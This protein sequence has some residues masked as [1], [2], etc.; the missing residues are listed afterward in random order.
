M[1]YFSSQVYIEEEEERLRNEYRLP[2]MTM[3]QLANVPM[4][5][6]RNHAEKGHV[7]ALEM[8]ELWNS[9][10]CPLCYLFNFSYTQLVIVT[11]RYS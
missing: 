6:C 10:V 1:P 3:L 5:A 4:E 7:E 9:M 8:W 2:G 11:G